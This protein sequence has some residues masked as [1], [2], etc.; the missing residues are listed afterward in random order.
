MPDHAPL[1]T[2]ERLQLLREEEAKEAAEEL[3]RYENDVRLYGK[4][5]GWDGWQGCGAILYPHRRQDDYV[6]ND[7]PECVLP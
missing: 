1:A 3:M 2:P 4:C 7:Y 6:C 5:V